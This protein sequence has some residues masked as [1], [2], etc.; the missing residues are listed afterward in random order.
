MIE[1]VKHIVYVGHDAL[2][3]EDRN[4]LSVAYKNYVCSRRAALRV[5]SF[6]LKAGHDKEGY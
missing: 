6:K 1:A 5:M 2:N 4:L 3:V